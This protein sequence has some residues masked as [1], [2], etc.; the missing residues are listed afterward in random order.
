MVNAVDWPAHDIERWVNAAVFAA[1]VPAITMS[2]SPPVARVG[3]LYVPGRTGCFECQERAYR[4]DFPLY[5]DLVER[6]RG[7]FVVRPPPSGPV[8]AIVGGQVA[9]EALHL[10]TGLCEPATLGTA[11][12]YDLRTMEITREAV[13]R[14]PGCP[15]CGVSAP[16]PRRLSELSARPQAAPTEAAEG[17]PMSTATLSPERLTPPRPATEAPRIEIVVPVY[18]EQAALPGSIRRLHEHLSAELPY[19]WRIVIA[20]NASTDQTP[21]LARALAGDLAGVEY[22]RLTER[23]R[24]RALRAAWS[25]SD[26][27][28]LC[29]MDV[30]LSTDLRGLA[31]ARRA[32]GVRPQ[33]RGHRHAAGAGRAGGARA[34]S[35]S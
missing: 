29:Y 23:G 32:A 28:V 14:D 1:G 26:A 35:V 18:N 5:D 21:R 24:G 15:V 4:R 17:G 10:L 6:R 33:R 8:C 19:T 12:L 25:R 2:H 11:W 30:D 20:D 13:P 9:L 22:L 3:P 27:E 31:S 7:R 34:P 16:G